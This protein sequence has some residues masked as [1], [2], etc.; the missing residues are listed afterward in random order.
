MKKITQDTKPIAYDR[1][2]ALSKN[3]NGGQTELYE[4][5]R[6]AQNLAKLKAAQIKPY[7][8]TDADMKVL[9]LK[10]RKLN[11]NDPLGNPVYFLRKDPKE[12]SK[13]SLNRFAAAVILNG[14]KEPKKKELK[15]EKTKEQIKIEQ[16]LTLKVRVQEERLKRF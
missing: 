11:P 8:V 1:G 4:K 5:T 14:S 3:K 15:I 7:R 16:E 10:H 12:L 13:F 2:K 6:H 9:N